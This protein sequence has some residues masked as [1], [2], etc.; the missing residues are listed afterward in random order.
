MDLNTAIATLNTNSGA[1]NAIAIVILV[2]VTGVYAGLTYKLV[3]IEDEREKGKERKL[4]NILL[5]EFKSNKSLLEDFDNELKNQPPL[6]GSN[7]PQYFSALE[8][9]V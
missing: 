6:L 8:K 5:A 2:V 9:M 1:I 4:M 7:L 3:K